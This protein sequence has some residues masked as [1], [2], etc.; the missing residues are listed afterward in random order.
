[1][2]LMLHFVQY[3]VHHVLCWDRAGRP[4]GDGHHRG[5]VSGAAVCPTLHVFQLPQQQ[6]PAGFTTD[7]RLT[8]HHPGALAF[9]S[10]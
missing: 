4:R 7:T 9:G 10:A 8:L 1:M 6:D 5:R 3:V 2:L